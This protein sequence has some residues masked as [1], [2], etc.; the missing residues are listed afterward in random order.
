MAAE[1]RARPEPR[2]GHTLRRPPRVHRLGRGGLASGRGQPAPGRP[3][4]ER[5]RHAGERRQ[6]LAAAPPSRDQLPARRRA[7]AFRGRG[8]ALLRDHG[9]RAGHV[10]RN[11]ARL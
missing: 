11:G 5:R 4:G 3:A 10:A 1:A 7:K 8:G 9:A 2:D 6:P